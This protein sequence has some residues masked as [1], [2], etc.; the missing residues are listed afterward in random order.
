VSSS[1]W[2]DG[3]TWNHEY[4]EVRAIPSSLR[5]APSRAFKRLERALGD[6]SMMRVLD[7]GAGT[8]RHAMYVASRGAHVHAVDSSEVACSIHLA[9]AKAVRVNRLIVVEIGSLDLTNLPDDKYDVIIDSYVSCH[10]LSALERQAFL[11]VLMSRLAPRGRLYTAGMGDKDS[12]YRRHVACRVPETIAL[13]SK[14]GVPK[15]LQP[16]DVAARD[17]DSLGRLCAS[18]TERFT[19]VVNGRSEM[20]EVHASVLTR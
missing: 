16:A 3:P 17:G 7:V 6:L 8:G 15:L 18:T 13:D 20:R 11:D 12:F 19:D 10:I 9:R 1:A 5:S 2:G 4:A 14:N